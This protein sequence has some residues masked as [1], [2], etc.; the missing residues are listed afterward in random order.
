MENCTISEPKEMKEFPAELARQ[1]KGVTFEDSNLT[2]QRHM[3]VL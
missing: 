1:F 3:T 2:V